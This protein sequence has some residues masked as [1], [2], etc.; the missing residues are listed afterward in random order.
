M[1]HSFTDPAVLQEEREIWVKLY[2][3]CFVCNDISVEISVENP[4]TGGCRVI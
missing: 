2:G 3:A 4:D 1:T